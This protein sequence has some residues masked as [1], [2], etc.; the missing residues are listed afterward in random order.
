MQH[1]QPPILVAHEGQNM[2]ADDA[3]WALVADAAG[4]ALTLPGLSRLSRRDL[5]DLW[6]ACR[7]AAGLPCER[8]PQ[9]AAA[10]LQA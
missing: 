10:P 1:R 7:G 8:H 5:H 4:V 9:P 6:T 2:A 3:A